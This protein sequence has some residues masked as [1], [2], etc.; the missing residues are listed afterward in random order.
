M[1]YD[2][3]IPF[4]ISFIIG[5]FH[6]LLQNTASDHT[7]YWDVGFGEMSGVLLPCKQVRILKDINSIL[8]V[9]KQL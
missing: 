6:L 2:N 3:Y 9:Y 8:K 4:T 1:L 5:R 7:F